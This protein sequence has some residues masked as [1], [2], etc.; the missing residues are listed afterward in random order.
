MLGIM[1]M[2]KSSLLAA[3]VGILY[4]QN[5]YA[6]STDL[7]ISIVIPNG[8]AKDAAEY[9]NHQINLSRSTDHFHVL[10]TNISQK[11]QRIWEGWNS[12]G[13]YNLSFE[14]TDS[15]G[16]LLYKLEHKKRKWTVNFPSIV[17]INPGEQFI[18][19]VYLNK[20]DWLLPF[21]KD[22]KGGDFEL[23]IQAIY[24]I[25]ENIDAKRMGIWTGKV[26]SQVE[27]CTLRY[28]KK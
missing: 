14:V 2:K 4:A 19:D 28:W 10:I 1:K 25:P 27:K 15:S 18:I 22:K 26:K 3:I 20:E 13:W 5:L 24:E 23:N 9:Q 16:G 17:S 21:L 12:W 11:P 8:D 7:K 6:Q